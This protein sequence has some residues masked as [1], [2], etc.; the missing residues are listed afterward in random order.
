MAQAPAAP[1]A[2]AAPTDPVVLALLGTNPATPSELLRAAKILVDLKHES[3][4]RTMIDRILT[5]RLDDTTLADL[6]EEFGAATLLRLASVPALKPASATLVDKILNAVDR[7]ARDPAQLTDLIARLTADASDAELVAVIAALRAGKD[8]AAA[9]LVT[10]LADPARAADR[11]EIGAA[12]VELGSDATGPLL[13]L[14]ET[15]PADVAVE[16]LHVLGRSP[17]PVVGDYLMAPAFAA[18]SPT[19]VQ[20]A[21]RRALRAQY[22]EIP[23]AGQAAARLRDKTQSLLKQSYVPTGEPRIAGATPAALY[24]WDAAKRQLTAET[25]TTEASDAVAAIRLA[26]EARRILPDNLTL[27]RLQLLALAQA[28]FEAGL[29]PSKAPYSA[30]A[31]KAIATTNTAELSD[32]LDF[33]LAEGY[34]AAA[35]EATRLLGASGETHLLYANSPQLS[36]LAKAVAHP[37]RR[38]RYA[39]LGAILALDPDRPFPGSS[40]VTDALDYFARSSGAPKALIVAWHKEEASRLAG[41][42]AGLGYEPDYTTDGAAAARLAQT[43]GDYEFALVD[44]AVG[45]ATSGQFLQRLRVDPRTAELPVAISAIYDENLAAERLARLVPPAVAVPR[46]HT[47]DGLAYELKLLARESNRGIVSREERAAQCAQSLRWIGRLAERGQSLYDLRRL[48]AAV[49]AT[50]DAPEVTEICL[51]VLA[52]LNTVRSQLA[53]AEVASRQ[54]API[55]IRQAAARGFGESVRRCGT[56]LTTDQIVAQY[57]RY[58]A[59]VTAD[60]ETQKVLASILDSIEQ[61]AAGEA[62]AAGREPLTTTP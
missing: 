6:E 38:L 19:A 39:A 30:S 54:A 45:G 62:L 34:P 4:A 12:L 29:A 20:A 33:A 16:A 3:I 26:G 2:P 24:R 49:L 35:A 14:L 7:T 13:A 52:R 15:A 1:P 47:V 60:K 46:P 17:D 57:E 27:R 21:A 55:G 8:A 22:G 50:L 53:L 5:Q 31:R 40:R 9:A 58:N 43:L 23:S 44:M 37:D 56:L 28:A 42:A 10:A 48:D 18:D 32:L 51:A 59:S 41:L 61:R 11:R 36:P 25:S